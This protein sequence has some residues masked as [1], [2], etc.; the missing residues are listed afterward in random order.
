MSDQKNENRNDALERFF[1]QKAEEYN[2][3]YNE[4]DWLKLEDRLNNLDQQRRRRTWRR[5][6]A[7]AVVLAFSI[8]AYLIINNQLQIDKLNRRLS[9]NQPTQVHQPSTPDAPPTE[10]EELTNSHS[11]GNTDQEPTLKSSEN[12]TIASKEQKNEPNPASANEN[13]RIQYKNYSLTVKPM[14]IV[15]ATL[16]FDVHSAKSSDIKLIKTKNSSV[17]ALATV[18]HSKP[19]LV[20]SRDN[21][22]KHNVVRASLGLV[23]GPDLSTAGSMAHFY[24]PGSKIGVTLDYNFNSRFAITG[25]IIRTRTLYTAKGGDYHPPIGYF[26][27]GSVPGKTVADC[28]LLDIPVSLKYNL[29]QFDR[30][31]FYT[32][33]GISSYIMLNEKYSFHYDNYQSGLK[34]EWNHKTG[35][36]YWLS[37]ASLSVGY[38]F[39]IL[40]HWSLRAE[41]YLRIPIKEVGWGKVNLYSMGTVVSLNYHFGH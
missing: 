33:A 39:D 8:L 30:S 31:R 27:N 18:S 5:L 19:T 25:G 28:V 29:L 11:D 24:D 1:Q 21:S 20:H 26:S 38:E 41:P 16:G 36:R 13:N 12:E 10:S 4:E 7:A 35:S 23:M 34:R 3:S 40:N 22:T 15:M 32:T 17:N 37:N 2:I 6:I 9:N 14:N